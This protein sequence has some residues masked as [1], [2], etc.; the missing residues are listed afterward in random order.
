MDVISSV[1]YENELVM[2]IAWNYIHGINEKSYI[3]KIVENINWNYL[4]QLAIDQKIFSLVYSTLQDFIPPSYQD[5]YNAKFQSINKMNLLI[6]EAMKTLTTKCED[7]KSMIFIKGIVLSQLIYDNPFFRMSNDI[8]M[9]IRESDIVSIDQMLKELGY[10]HACGK[11]NPYVMDLKNPLI[12][13]YPILKDYKHHEYFEYYKKQGTNYILIELQ[14][15]IHGTIVFDKIHQFLE[16]TDEIMICGTKIQT[17]SLEHTLLYLIESIHTDAN[18]YVRGPKLNK[19]LELG[20]FILKFQKIIDWKK[21]IEKAADFEMTG[22]VY[23]VFKELNELFQFSIP[24]EM[25]E[26]HKLQISKPSSLS[27]DWGI[28]LVERLFQTDQERQ[29]EIFKMLKMLCYGTNHLHHAFVV[30]SE[31]IN[32]KSFTE[33]TL[34]V[35]NNKY[36]YK[37]H[38]RPTINSTYLTFTFYLPEELIQSRYDWDII[39]NTI[40]PKSDSEILDLHTYSFAKVNGKIHIGPCNSGTIE[41][42]DNVVFRLNIPLSDIYSHFKER[43]L[44]YKI[45]MRERIYGP[46]YHI[47]NRDGYIDKSF[48]LSPTLIRIQN[49]ELN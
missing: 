32:S 36:N 5:L 30:N 1:K 17:L 48:W 8:D 19:Y 14:R 6:Y 20:L 16:A 44:A 12:L 42:I 21:A 24:N 35:V 37:L 33:D 27:L 23:T 15:Q 28:P 11:E 13:P 10:F 4:Y 46:I 18:W 26:Q 43:V 45:I 49:E 39:F 40:D 7:R 41:Q 31:Y 9:L 47:L 29:K 22:L 2:Q 34:F 38:Y 25:V 3:Y